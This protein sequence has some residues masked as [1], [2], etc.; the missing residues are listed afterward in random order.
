MEENIKNI[1]LLGEN[2]NND[3]LNDTLKLLQMN[4]NIKQKDMAI[5]LQVSEITIKRNIK[6][7]KEKGFIE[8]VGARKNG[9]WKILKNN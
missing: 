7:L 6:E 5:K 9:Y 2:V 4:P 8:R 3:T 1:I